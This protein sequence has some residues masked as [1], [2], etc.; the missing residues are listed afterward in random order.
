[1][2]KFNDYLYLKLV[3]TPLKRFVG[4]PCHHSTYTYE[5]KKLWDFKIAADIQEWS[6]FK[7]YVNIYVI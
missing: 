4:I 1:M 6:K 5:T 3:Y 7:I 2:Q